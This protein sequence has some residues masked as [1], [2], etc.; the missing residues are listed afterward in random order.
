MTKY[1][2]GN[3]KCVAWQSLAPESSVNNNGK[4]LKHVK[5][6]KKCHGSCN[7]PEKKIEEGR[8]QIFLFFYI[9]FFSE[10]TTLAN[11]TKVSAKICQFIFLFQNRK[12]RLKCFGSGMSGYR[13]HKTFFRFA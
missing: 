10:A 4:C 7:I 13:N 6:G 2:A 11:F 1:T 5:E 8:H 9:F 3:I 12:K